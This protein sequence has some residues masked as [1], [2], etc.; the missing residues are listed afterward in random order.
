M[1]RPVRGI[2]VVL[3]LAP[4]IVRPASA[5]AETLL[6]VEQFGTRADDETF[7]LAADAGGTS[8]VVGRTFGGLP[9]FT[10]AGASDAFVF[11]HDS[12]GAPVW[13]S[14]F[15]TPG[16]DVATG[17]ATNAGGAVYVVGGVD[18]ALPGKAS[19]GS[20]DAFARK[21][22]PDGTV[23]WTKQFGTSGY[24]IATAVAVHG[25]GIYLASLWDGGGSGILLRYSASGTVRWKRHVPAGFHLPVAADA[26]GVYVGGTV[27]TTDQD[28][29]AFLRQY[30]DEGSVGWTRRFGTEGYDQPLGLAVRGG[31]VHVSGLTQGSMTGTNQGLSD[32]FVRTYGV[33]GTRG[34]TRQWGTADSDWAWDVELDDPGNAYVVGFVGPD[35][36]ATK[37]D[38]D[39]VELWTNELSTSDDEEARSVVLAGGIVYVAGSTAGRLDGSTGPPRGLDA[40]I[41]SFGPG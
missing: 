27:E 11:G 16:D 30:D 1:R 12:D 14:Q 26:S 35:A 29:N 9:G 21:Y 4:S 2:A 3:L 37:L 34:W 25:R 39:G 6:W 17:V 18:G 10:S 23:A 19:R 7:H 22:R 15:G 13:T 40:F 5:S 33:D 31:I 24:D 32:A 20:W 8:F 28:A 38:P 41:A 36:F